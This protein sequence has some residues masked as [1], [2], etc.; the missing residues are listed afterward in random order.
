M[1]AEFLSSPPRDESFPWTTRLDL[2][3]DGRPGGVS[4]DLRIRTRSALQE[5]RREHGITGR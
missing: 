5:L 3:L 4:V 1:A 2:Y